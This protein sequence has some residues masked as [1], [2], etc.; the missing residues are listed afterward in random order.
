M[1]VVPVLHEFWTCPLCLSNFSTREACEN[2]GGDVPELPDW[3]KVG[4][5]VWKGGEEAL[6]SGIEVINIAQSKG[7]HNHL[8]YVLLEK[9]GRSG[10]WSSGPVR[11]ENDLS[12]SLRS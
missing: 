5:P 12:F 4:A 10:P 8:L 11:D 1:K 3:V 7:G 6:I 9:V 2:A